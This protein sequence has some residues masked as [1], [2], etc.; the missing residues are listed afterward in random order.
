MYELKDYY[1]ILGVE[2]S[3]SLDEIRKAYKIKAL[4]FH[5]DRNP[6]DTEAEE[7]FKEVNEAHEILSN[8]NA[9]R[10]HDK[11]MDIGDIGEPI[12][13]DDLDEFSFMDY[14]SAL[15]KVYGTD[16][17][18]IIQQITQFWEQQ[19][20]TSFEFKSKGLVHGM[21]IDDFIED[22]G[23]MRRRDGKDYFVRA[24]NA[25]IFVDSKDTFQE[26]KPANINLGGK[27]KKFD[28]YVS[29]PSGANVPGVYGLTGMNC[30]IYGVI[31]YTFI[32]RVG[33][34]QVNL[35]LKG[36]IEL[37]LS[38]SSICELNIQG[39][40]LYQSVPALDCVRYRPIGTER[41]KHVLMLHTAGT[42]VNIKYRK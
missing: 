14:M 27:V 36:D 5:P 33:G 9:R 15:A 29:F 10:I 34:G 42:K 31:D 12:N 8:E 24:R 17:F 21:T 30:S 1:Q 39:M 32:L 19:A 16:P 2:S 26:K 20:R 35:N 11:L 28:Y 40:E 37:S 3:A 7:I 41:N 38:N 22:R 23:V 4:E 18:T 13:P 25:A 6:D